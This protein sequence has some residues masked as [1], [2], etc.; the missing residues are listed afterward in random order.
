MSGCVGKRRL[1]KEGNVIS[2]QITEQWNPDD[3]RTEEEKK[4]KAEE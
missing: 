1:R 2:K 4:G 3:G